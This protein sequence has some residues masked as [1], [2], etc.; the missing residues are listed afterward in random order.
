MVN[1]IDIQPK[2]KKVFKNKTV[3]KVE[4]KG[5]RKKKINWKKT[6][7]ALLFLVDGMKNNHDKFSF[8]ITALLPT[9]DTSY[10][11]Y[12]SYN[13]DLGDSLENYEEY[14]SG[15]VKDTENYLEADLLSISF[16]VKN[17]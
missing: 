4:V 1:G 3:Y 5:Q 14:L 17:T 7:E 6:K 12:L 9:G 15:K 11:S 2:F 10:T 13:A 8:S 16:I